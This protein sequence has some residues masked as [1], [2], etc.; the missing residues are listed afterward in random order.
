LDADALV[1]SLRQRGEAVRGARGVRDD[2]VLGRVVLGVVHADDERRVLVRGR[3]RDDDLLGTGV[4]VG[5]GLGRIGEEAGRLDDDVRAELAPVEVR[6]VALSRRG[7]GLAADRDG[8]VR[9][10]HLLVE[11]AQDRVVL[12]QVR[13]SLVVREVVD[14]DD[15][16]VRAGSQ[17]G[18]VE[19]TSN[20]AEAVDSDLDGHLVSS[21]RAKA[22]RL[23]D[24]SA[25]VRGHRVSGSLKT[26]YYPGSSPCAL[27]TSQG[28]SSH[29]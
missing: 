19:V 5:L 17:D 16:D 15:L 25:S 3:G 26:A 11:T 18:A 9:V 10:A 4:D 12:E 7:E 21:A 24:E 2:V 8:V 23:V 28:P 27:R 20:T 22:A 14:A 29:L 13:E 1:E 6:G